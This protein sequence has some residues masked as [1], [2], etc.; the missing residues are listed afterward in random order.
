MTTSQNEPCDKAFS[1][2]V[3]QHNNAV[4]TWFFLE[5]SKQQSDFAGQHG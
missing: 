3:R 4:A 2:L 1:F 5:H